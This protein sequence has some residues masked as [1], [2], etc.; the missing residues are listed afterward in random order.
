MCAL[1][2]VDQIARSTAYVPDRM[3]QN[4]NLIGATNKS[5]HRSQ[6][7]KTGPDGTFAWNVAAA[8]IHAIEE[9]RLFVLI[10]FFTLVGLIVYRLA[11]QEP[12][13]FVLIGSGFGFFGLLLWSLIL[14]RYARWM[15]LLLAGWAGFSLLPLHG[16]FF[17]GEMLNY[18]AFGV[19]E[20]Q[21]DRI[22]SSREDGQRIVVSDIIPLDGA[23]TLEIRRARLLVRKGPTLAAGNVIQGPMRLARVPGPVVVGGFD[24]QFH[25]YFDGIGAYGNTTQPPIIVGTNSIAPLRN[26]ITNVRQTIGKRIDLVLEQPAR[27]IARA[28]TVGDQSG[29]SDETRDTMAAA[30]LA[31]VLAISGLHLTLVAGGVFFALRLLL[32]MS[33]SLGQNLPVKKVAAIA[34]I[35]AALIY[36]ALSGA[37]VSAVRATVMLVLV[38]GAV[39]VGRR[40]ITMRTVAIAAIF[41]IITDPASV[42][43]PSFQLSFSAVVALVGAYELIPNRGDIQRGAFRR[44]VGFFGGMAITSL[45][46]GAATALFAAYH[47]QQTAPLG[48]LGNLAAL[49]LVGFV[50]LPSAFIAVLLMPLGFEAPFLRLMG[51]ATDIIFAIAEH[52]AGWSDG[53][54]GSPLLLP[55]SLVIGL[56]ALGWFA[57]FE[58]RIRLAGPI[59]GIVLVAAVGVDRA[60]DILIADS[61]KAVAVRGDNGLGL[62]SGRTGSFAV[63]AWEETYQEPIAPKLAGLRCDSIGCLIE[64]PEGFTISLVKNREAFREDCAM[65]DLVVT[66]LTAPQTCRDLTQVID[67]QDLQY[68]GMHWLAWDVKRHE[69]LVR[70]AISDKNR[71]WRSNRPEN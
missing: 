63:N 22:L 44:L 35:I 4:E 36:L 23:R 8:A 42:F 12:A 68:G 45:V 9:R 61:T 43:R 56:F 53:I 15:P 66:R 49:P 16:H 19:Y 70:P 46:A 3:P 41:V 25:A 34:G 31:H 40:A 6:Y 29:V 20:V 21:I 30:G 26:I 51:Q 37:S 47:F 64:R 48:V 52:V 13:P 62:I 1:G 55:V 71:P 59:F 54:G 69:F 5:V 2:V 50:V 10:P 27:G 60:P 39:L 38:F 14:G 18:P 11:G 7:H 67:Y 58:G 17:G 33:Y 57:F 65:A 24:S 32:A 28:L